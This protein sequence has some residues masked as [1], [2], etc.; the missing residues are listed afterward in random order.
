MT[1]IYG[2][3]NCDTMKKAFKWL[4]EKGVNYTFHDY[5]KEG[6]DEDVL[7]AALDQHGWENVINRRGT[8]WRQLPKDIQDSMNDKKAVQVALDKPSI[9]KRPLLVNKG[10]ITLDFKPEIYAKIFCQLERNWWRYRDLKVI[11]H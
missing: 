11:T 2:I 10:K 6:V 8:T 3:K 4:D 1:D 7:K 9:I 5:K